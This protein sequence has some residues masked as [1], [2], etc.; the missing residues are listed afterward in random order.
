MFGY[1]PP[2]QTQE[3]RTIR[4]A[5]LDQ[6]EKGLAGNSGNFP[7]FSPYGSS[8]ESNPLHVLMVEMAVHE[9]RVFA[10]RYDPFLD[11]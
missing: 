9:H 3:E 7:R 2:S 6:I 8:A 1:V 11:C 10:S 4:L 5:R